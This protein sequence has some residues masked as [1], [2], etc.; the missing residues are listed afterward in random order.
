MHFVRNQNFTKNFWIDK[1]GKIVP[2][3]SHL[4]YAQKMFPMTED[5]YYYMYK[6]GY[7]K[8]VVEGIREMFVHY[9]RGMPPNNIQKKS[10]EEISFHYGFKG[11]WMD[12]PEFNPDLAES[13]LSY[14]EFFV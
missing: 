3:Y 13:I 11:D 5:P 8:V 2:V 4:D 14:K 7:I 10:L 6:D 1:T 12:I 9:K